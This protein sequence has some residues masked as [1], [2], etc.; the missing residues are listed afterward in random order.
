MKKKF[1][2]I[3]NLNFKFEK[4]YVFKKL[5]FSIESPKIVG[6]FGDEE[7]GKTT[8]LNI[9]SGSIRTLNVR[10]SNGKCSWVLGS[11]TPFS[12]NITLHQNLKFLSLLY[13]VKD[14]S[15]VSNILELSGLSINKKNLYKDIN[16]SQ[17]F[18]LNFYSALQVGFD[19][20]FLDEQFFPV[21]LSADEVKLSIEQI[22]SD[23]K[24]LVL[25]GKNKKRL[26]SLCEN[27]YI[28]NETALNKISNANINN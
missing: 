23:G 13:G 7:S 6:I 2:T 24:S 17:K 20:I 3:N 8:L 18:S 22:K 12:S 14:E 11:Y 4:K 25:A 19:F 27:C 15:F 21:H 1:I 5:N 16:R 28:I 10:E 26:E 9:I